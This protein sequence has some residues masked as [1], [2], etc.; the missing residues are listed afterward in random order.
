MKDRLAKWMLQYAPWYIDAVE[1]AQEIH[2]G[3]AALLIICPPV[4]LAAAL[5]GIL[6]STAVE[7][8]K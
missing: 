3:L 1:R 4:A 8:F 7:L 2:P 6:L 5:M